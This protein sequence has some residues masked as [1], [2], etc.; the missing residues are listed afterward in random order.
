MPFLFSTRPPTIM[1]KISAARA[2]LP[3]TIPTSSFSPLARRPFS[4]GVGK[5]LAYLERQ[6]D[7]PGIAFLT[8]D[9]PAARNAI[10]TQMLEE[11]GGI[12]ETL[13]GDN[14]TLALIIRSNAPGAFCAGADLKERLDMSSERFHDW[15]V[16]LG[17]TF[18]ALEVLPMP[19]IAA[20]DGV[21]LGGG[22][23][24]GLIA[25][26]R[27][28][29]PAATHI[30]LPETRHAIIPGA[31]GTQRLTRVIGASQAKYHILT[32]KIFDAA[33]AYERGIV[34]LLAHEGDRETAALQM[35]LSVAHEMS[36]R[37]EQQRLNT[38]IS[39]HLTFCLSLLPRLARTAGTSRSKSRHRR[40]R[41]QRHVSP[42]G[43]QALHCIA[44]KAHSS[45]LP[46]HFCRDSGLAIERQHYETLFQ[47]RDRREGLEA[48]SQ[49]RKPNYEGR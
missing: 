25:D 6:E 27:V 18:R 12:V 26:V 8:L 40:G 37:G 15:H 9:R 45:F 48:F 32:G 39:T 34:D 10:N 16:K 5:P 46:F 23:E 24:L 17:R 20:I 31:G 13:R 38:I 36:Q 44:W 35:S 11:L 19:T 43:G 7:N 49:K 22:L 1:L 42:R 3:R 14:S 28:A 29:G 41:A 47:T 30:G 33:Y 2:A 4:I 21:A